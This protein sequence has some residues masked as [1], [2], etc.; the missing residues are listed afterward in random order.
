MPTTKA[1]LVVTFNQKFYD[2]HREEL[3][4]YLNKNLNGLQLADM[5]P[6]F[7]LGTLFPKVIF[8][9]QNQ[10]IKHF[11]ILES[12]DLEM[13]TEW[14]HLQFHMRGVDMDFELDY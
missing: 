6:E 8:K 3:M 4:E 13:T 7:T 14:P 12:S 2:A 5:A 1:G 9:L 10:K 11:K